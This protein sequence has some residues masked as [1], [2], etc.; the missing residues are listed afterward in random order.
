MLH[1]AN[2]TAIEFLGQLA[3]HR[4]HQAEQRPVVADEIDDKG[5][6]QRR[7]DAFVRD[8]ITDIE[9]VAWMLPV[10]RCN[11]FAG[12]QIR[13]GH[14]LDRSKAELRFDQIRDGPCRC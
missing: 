12:L 9:Q 11:E 4:R 14:H 6:A 10:E 8:Q 3:A 1:H 7:V 2:E 5:L 13:E